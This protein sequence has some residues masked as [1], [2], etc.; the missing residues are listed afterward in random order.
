MLFKNQYI[1]CKTFYN[2]FNVMNCALKK[3][4]GKQT[5]NKNFKVIEHVFIFLKI[6]QNH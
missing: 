2:L 3:K 6:Y 4:P 1:V 5:Y